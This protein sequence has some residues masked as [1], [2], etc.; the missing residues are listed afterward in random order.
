LMLLSFRSRLEILRSL[1]CA[2]HMA[3]RL[4]TAALFRLKIASSGRGALARTRCAH[5]NYI[6][7]KTEG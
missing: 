1:C 4:S 3:H 6:N 7:K 2:L 5:L